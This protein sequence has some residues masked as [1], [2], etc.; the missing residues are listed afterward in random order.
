VGLISGLFDVYGQTQLW[1]WYIIL[2]IG[3]ILTTI[4]IIC[5]VTQNRKW[6]IDDTAIACCLYILSAVAIA[7]AT[8]ILVLIGLF[9][10]VSRLYKDNKTIN[11]GD[12]VISTKRG[13]DVEY[14]VIY[15]ND[16]DTYTLKCI[17]TDSKEKY[18]R[19]S[20]DILK[21]IKRVR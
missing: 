14:M 1:V 8:V 20:G 3:S 17:R 18:G 19:V 15:V 9:W 6:E 11:V 7:I 4:Y 10:I 5:Y 21:V 2:L 12:I 16:D 13:K